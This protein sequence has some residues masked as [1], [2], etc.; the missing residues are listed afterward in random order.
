VWHKNCFEHIYEHTNAQKLKL[1]MQVCWE[2]DKSFHV[3]TSNE[4]LHRVVGDLDSNQQ[5]KKTEGVF[6]FE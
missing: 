3:E 2:A 6:L 1:E 5:L 4:I